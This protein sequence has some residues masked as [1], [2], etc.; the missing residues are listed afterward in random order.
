MKRRRRLS[1]LLTGLMTT[2][3]TAGLIAAPTAASAQPDPPSV[4]SSDNRRDSSSVPAAQRDAVLGKGW[5]SSDDL[6]WTTTSDAQGFHILT[7]SESAGYAWKTTASL[8]EPGFDADAWIGNA[9]VTASGKRAVVVYAPRTFTNN[10]KLMARGGFTAVV[11]LK[12][13]SVKKLNVTASLS[14]YNPG[15]GLGETAV[16]TQ[17]AGEDRE[18]TRLIT[19]DST[20]GKMAQPILTSGQVT[21]ATESK[22]G[23][24][25]AFGSQLV[26]VSAEGTKK[27]LAKT[28]GTPYRIT[29]DVDG[30]LVFLDR[31]ARKNKQ[32]EATAYIKRLPKGG[33]PTVIGEGKLSAIGLTGASGRVFLTGEVREAEPLPRSVER[34]QGSAK[35]AT[36]S[37]GGRTVVEH[38]VWADGVGSPEYLRREQA[39]EARAVAIET[40]IMDTG[41]Q[42]DFTVKPL[43]SISKE[44]EE[45][46]APSPRLTTKNPA[47]GTKDGTGGPSSSVST[48]GALAVGSRTEV[49]ESER[50]CSVPRN[51]PRNQAMQPKPRQVEWAVDQAVTGYLNTHV[52][53]PANWKNLGMPA[54]SPQSLFLNPALEG[55]GRVPAQIMLGITAQES[56]MW[57]AAQSAVP[58]VTANPL[59]GNYYGIDLY[60]GNAANDW[61]VD[62]AEADCG[63]GVAQVTDHMRLA[64]RENGE[65]GAAWDYQKQRAVALDYT[66]NVAAGLQIL[67]EKWN[68]ARRAGVVVHDGDPKR[69]EN[70]FLA[71]WSYNSGFYENVNGNE[72]WGVGWANNPANPEWDAGR[73]PFMEDRLGNEDASAAARPQHWPYPE[74]VLGFAAHPPA[75]IESPGTMVAAF[76][77]AWWNGTDGDATINGSAKQNRARL[78]PPEDLFCGPYNECDPAKISDSASNDSNT[79]GPCMRSDFRCWWH[80][81][82]T[83]KNDCSYSCGNEF[84]RFNSTYPEEADG[85]AYPPVCTTTGLPAGARVVDDVPGGTPVVRPGCSNSGWTNQGSFAFDFG[86]GEAGTGGATVWPSK[87][88]THQLGAGFGSHFYMSSTRSGAKGSRLEATGTWRL[89]SALGQWGRVMVHI[90]DHGATTQQ[91]RYTIYSGATM[92]GERYIPTRHRKNTWVNLGVFDFTGTGIPSVKLSTVTEE[93]TGDD[94][95]AWDAMAFVPLAAKPKEFVAVLGDSYASG[96]GAG[97]YT[98]VSNNNYGN[99][100]WNACRRSNSS[101]ARKATLPGYGST[102]GALADSN[103]PS[104]DFQFVACSGA[105]SWQLSGQ[106]DEWGYDGNFHEIPQNRSGVLD[107]NTTRVMLTIGGNDAKFPAVVQA[108][109][110]VGC[111][112]EDEMKR[113]I[114]AATVAVKATVTDISNRAGNAKIILLGYPQLF[115]ESDTFCVSGVGGAGM[116]RLNS[117]AR[118]MKD[119]QAAMVA[120][121]RQAGVRVVFESPDPDFEGRRACDDPEGIHKLIAGQQGE[122]DFPCLGSSWCISR[123][124]YHPSTVG[125]TAYAAALVRALSKP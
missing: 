107:G 31:Q 45:G 3:I 88:D 1:E 89:N 68:Q 93:G 18:Q 34:L 112:A 95:I 46:R 13:G 85:T 19:V 58:G 100:T 65:G 116:I 81:S 90:P 97:S 24:V 50:T 101:W 121:L 36:V 43:A 59:I 122:G 28:S 26:S 4:G 78:K 69:L 9:C 41:K 56:N 7:A 86:P 8:S 35:D 12:S 91:A 113:D 32:I 44:W 109:A 2:T 61:D 10:P 74:K 80:Q 114:D 73:T 70:W 42:A 49:V 55:G 6:A 37:T 124:S 105:R 102:M 111:P 39:T 16:L 11:D 79:S 82:V 98:T 118:Y 99:S 67:V 120:D 38:T 52:A 20:T 60:D 57:Q 115:N 48:A 104:L 62:F 54:Y 83:W 94:R 5:R 17:S 75:F 22:D 72:P 21:S 51:D 84:L 108:C 53:R 40:T 125:T 47:A 117:M 92:V 96:E 27:V 77:A 71:L 29:P 103:D 14:Y 15:C 87:V 110:T 76:R 63:Y 23:I 66:A 106:P 25:A 119:K 33:K 123:E 30:G 64:G